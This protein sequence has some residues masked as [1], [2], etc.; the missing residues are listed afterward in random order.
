MTSSA[1]LSSASKNLSPISSPARVYAALSED[2]GVS[3]RVQMRAVKMKPIKYLEVLVH[4]SNLFMD[5]TIWFRL[6]ELLSV[7]VE[8]MND[9]RSY[10]LYK[11]SNSL[12]Q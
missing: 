8:A 7:A 5:D 11:P 4:D 10:I 9:Q 6:K 2:E 1:L 12:C 3:K